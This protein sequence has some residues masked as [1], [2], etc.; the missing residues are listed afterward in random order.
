MYPEE[1]LK[2]LLEYL[3]EMRQ[4][5]GSSAIAQEMK[6]SRRTVQYDIKRL[7]EWLETQGFSPVQQIHKEGFFLKKAEKDAIKQKL[8]ELDETRVFTPLERKIRLLFWVA[9]SDKRLVNEDIAYLNDVS[10]ATVMQDLKELKQEMA[11]YFV[12]L[13][14]DPKKGKNLKG[15][16]QHIR[17]F[18]VLYCLEQHRETTLTQEL[19][20]IQ[21]NWEELEFET[22]HQTVSENLNK[23]EEVFGVHYTDEMQ[24]LL[25]QIALLFLVR[26][27]QG[28]IVE[29][30]TSDSSLLQKS[31]ELLYQTVLEDHWLAAHPEEAVF[32][33]Q[34]LFGANRLRDETETEAR[35]EHCVEE[36]IHRFE[37]FASVTFDQR[38]QLKKDLI[39]HLKP[40]FFRIMYGFHTSLSIYEDIQ[41]DYSEVY[42]LTKLA[43]QPFEELLGKRVPENELALIAILFGGYL[44][45]E[46]NPLVQ[47]MTLQIVCSK[48]IGTSRFIENQLKELLPG[49]V[50]FL[51]P[52]SLRKFEEKQ[53]DADL[54][55]TTIPLEAKGRKVVTVEPLL[56]QTQK[57]AVLME[58]GLST[59]SVSSRPIADLLDVIERHATI[60]N[61]SALK[62]DLERFLYAKSAPDKQPGGKSL[63]DSLPESHIRFEKQAADWPSAIWKAAEPLLEKGFITDDY[64]RAMIENILEFGPYVVLAPGVAMPHAE[65]ARGVRR[66]GMSLLL[67]EEPVPFSDKERD[68]ISV[69]LVLASDNQSDHLQAL[70]E[71]GKIIGK[72]SFLE[73]LK[74]AAQAKDVRELLASI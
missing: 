54:I 31:G 47:Q 17:Q 48:G 35:L 43:V 51:P 58:M 9:L 38:G 44:R 22:L 65:A 70:R 67:L 27:R 28:H 36:V 66:S 15:E 3:L 25:L 60:H 16:E 11:P 56:T 5:V 61:R 71:W 73:K 68:Q 24:E 62:A 49:R 14:H 26:I 41:K 64:P 19:L 10:R 57:E 39:L 50:A 32:I 4:P 21:E 42:E 29:A 34:F 74:Q 30:G 18:L 45:R 63:L 12:E 69:V 8:G 53:P 46:K 55:V 52:L 7:D 6:V 33:G 72:P 1:R 59:Q 23:V 13:G 40:A 37:K 20:L 2:W